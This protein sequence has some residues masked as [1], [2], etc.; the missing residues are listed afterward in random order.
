M[1]QVGSDPFFFKFK[2][3]LFVYILF[4][5]NTG[6]PPHFTEEN[7]ELVNAPTYNPEIKMIR[8]GWVANGTRTG[9]PPSVQDNEEYDNDSLA[10]LPKSVEEKFKKVVGQ[11]Q[12]PSDLKNVDGLTQKNQEPEKE[13]QSYFEDDEDDLY[14]DVDP[15]ITE[16]E[17]ESSEELSNRML[18]SMNPINLDDEAI[19]A[20]VDDILNNQVCYKYF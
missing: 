10:E 6:K 5:G 8:N 9:L 4:L 14:D 16:T 15:L 20:E 17:I 11:I 18:D 7:W 19:N 1:F 12:I 2:N 13:I 3:E